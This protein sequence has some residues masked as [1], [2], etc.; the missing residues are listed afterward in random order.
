MLTSD[1]GYDIILSEGDGSEP[2]GTPNGRSRDRRWPAKK[3]ANG[4]GGSE[5]PTIKKEEIKPMKYYMNKITTMVCVSR[6]TLSNENWFE[7]SREVYLL[8]VE[9]NGEKYAKIC[10]NA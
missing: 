4:T 5:P 1:P 7:I 3:Q 10:G 6:R 9:K 8:E 2:D